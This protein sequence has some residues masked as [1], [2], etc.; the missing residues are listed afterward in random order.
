MIR[1]AISWNVIVLAG[2][3]VW[4]V[5][6]EVTVTPVVKDETHVFAAFTAQSSFDDDVRKIVQSGL[7]TTFTYTLEL[8]RP[9][10]WFDHRLCG[11]TV[12]ASVT[13]DSLTSRYQVQKLR[14]GRVTRSERLEKYA[15]V[16]EWMTVFDQVPLEPCEALEPNVDYYVRVR[17]RTSPRPNSFSLWPFGRDDASG[18]KDFTYVR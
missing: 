15:D 1:R 18:R 12:G 17:L 4:A 9:S 3:L 2:A 11:T 6:G 13:F 7:L 8:N 14:E 16:R 10:V 5:P